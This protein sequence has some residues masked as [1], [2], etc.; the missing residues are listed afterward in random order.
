MRGAGT[1]PE[2][3]PLELRAV[4][5][6]R[7]AIPL[8]MIGAP[9]VGRLV[10][11][12]DGLGR[13]LAAGSCALMAVVLVLL[14]VRHARQRARGVLVRLDSYGVTVGAGPAV[15]WS[16]LS[17]VRSGKHGAVIMVPRPGVELPVVP[18]GMPFG[19]PERQKAVY[20]RR[21]GSPLVLIPGTLDATGP[22][23]L[24]AVRRLGGIPATGSESAA[25]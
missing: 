3:G 18:H 11:G 23:I 2:V 9:S 4:G 8:L 16:D 12:P 15:P 14:L 19:R 20:T 22:R 7:L 17:A 13:L 6:A 24:A 5:S 10:T 1:L 25:S 21:Y